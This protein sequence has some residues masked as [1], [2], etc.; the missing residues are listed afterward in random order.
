MS[1]LNP[2]PGRL[3]KRA[4]R[5]SGDVAKLQRKLWKAIVRAETI[6]E[7]GGDDYLALKAAH[8]LSQVAATFLKAVE[9][10]ELEVR[11]EE[12]ER[13]AAA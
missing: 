11:L 6:M 9:V 8:C 3:A 10:G 4:R 5:H 1:N 7:P 12:L 13:R 2:V